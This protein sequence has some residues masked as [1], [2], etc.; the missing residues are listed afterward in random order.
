[1]NNNKKESHNFPPVSFISCLHCPLGLAVFWKQ[2]A[3]LNG[4]QAS[5][6]EILLDLT[7]LASCT[8]SLVYNK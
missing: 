5:S 8:S 3:E 1:M 6:P 7:F 2:G 4:T